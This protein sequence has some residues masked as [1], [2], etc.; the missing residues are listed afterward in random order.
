MACTINFNSDSTGSFYAGDIVTGTVI[1]E[2]KNEQKFQSIDLKV[3]GLCKAQWTRPMPTMPYIKIYSEKKKVLSLLMTDIFRDLSVGSVLPAGIHHYPFH[4]ALPPDLPS[5]FDSSVAKIT[6]T[7]KIQSKPAYKLRKLATFNVFAN[8]NINH[9][10]EYLMPTFNEFHKTF[11][12]SGK[13]TICIKTY[14]AFAPR[15]TI[16]FEVTLVNEKKVKIRKIVISLI[17]KIKYSV[18]S[19]YAD[20]ERKMCKAEYRKFSLNI[21]EL[22]FFNMEIPHIIPSTM[23]I[24][25]PMVHISYIFRIQVI[26]PF[27][28]SL[29][30]DMSVIVAT[31]PV[32]HYDFK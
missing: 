31:A 14:R 27:H 16:P 26:F 21:A 8:V 2:L 10:E 24:E 29:Q 30:E 13:F 18:H 22:C 15:Q 1:L 32:L 5:T 25:D 7:V 20:E 6:Y 17:Q 28:T 12:N 19:G 3:T 11:R 23:D 9:M 4:F